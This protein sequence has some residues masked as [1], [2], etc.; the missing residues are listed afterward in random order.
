MITKT[1]ILIHSVKT[2][3]ILYFIE[4]L[5]ACAHIFSH[6]LCLKS[7]PFALH[8]WPP[9]DHLSHTLRHNFL[10]LFP[11]SF[12]SY[13]VVMDIKM[14]S[15][16]WSCTAHQKIPCISQHNRMTFRQKGKEGWTGSFLWESC[17]W[18]EITALSWE[19]PRLSRQVGARQRSG[20]RSGWKLSRIGRGCREST[21]QGAITPM[22]GHSW[23][24]PWLTGCCAWACIHRR[25]QCSMALASWIA[26]RM[27]CAFT[28]DWS[29]TASNSSSTKL[30]FC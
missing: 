23:S 12:M 13:T 7:F 1:A 4:R 17:Y 6:R 10:W 19:N 20:K 22:P 30:L 8:Y 25:L 3:Y 21:P 5:T 15:K 14:L 18:P 27:P 24:P 29:I 16:F 26:P 9:L 11:R 2:A 28:S